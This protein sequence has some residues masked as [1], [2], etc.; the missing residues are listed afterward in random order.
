M[1]SRFILVFFIAGVI[2]SCTKDQMPLNIEYEN[3]LR[4]KIQAV[5]PDNS[6]AYYILPDGSDLSEI[7]Q[8]PKNPLTREKVELGKLIF[9]ET[10]FA[11]DAMS[12][13][14]IGT[15]SCAS[16]HI[17]EAGFRPGAFQG[18]A[19]GGLDFGVNGED[20]RRNTAYLESELDVQ[21]AR[22][23]S[24]TNVAFVENTFWNGQFGAGD[25]NEGIHDYYGI[26]EDLRELNERGFKGIET[27]NFEGIKTHRIAINK[28]LLDQYGYTELFDHAF[29]EVAEEERYN[30]DIGSLA[31]SAYIRTI[32]TDKAPF[33]E[34]LRGD[35]DAMT[36]QQKKGAI[37]F[38]GKAQCYNCH[39]EQNLGSAEFHALG[40][41][42]MDQYPG[43]NTSADDLR[44]L[45]RFSFTRLPQDS[46]K[47]KV[48]QLYNM[49]DTKF[50]FHGSSK[51]T[52]EEVIDYKLEA[53]SE[54]PRVRQGLISTKLNTITLTDLEKD[55]LLDF[56]ENGL[57]DPDLVRY[58]P[59][60]VL[61]GQCF[62][63]A[64]SQSMSDL[65][66]Q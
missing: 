19:D 40:V 54:N 36:T 26:G 18:I 34:W 10:A 3:I 27:Q 55:Q 66:C 23:L 65:G 57:R 25:N 29:P 7:P 24:L 22:P 2:L 14:G 5:S 39:Y 42:D 11:Q 38:F 43:Y 49:I 9:H 17:A 4:D 63:N 62:P 44:N 13:E 6:M 50:Y 30:T 28:E 47:F 52:L 16:C 64:D 59:G 8:D 1:S 31:I 58:K 45:G 37:L 61:S 15:Y 20:R 48:P 41:G 21:S 32:L 51:T 33:Q 12:E 56:L 35:I 60:S 53:I 46:F